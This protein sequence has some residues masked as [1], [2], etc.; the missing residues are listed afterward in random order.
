MA[1]SG[2]LHFPIFFALLLSLPLFA[3]TGQ[4]VAQPSVGNPVTLPVQASSVAS[5]SGIPTN[6]SLQINS[7]TLHWQGF[8]GNVT[9]SIALAYGNSTLRSWN[10]SSVF[11]QVYACTSQN[12]DFSALNSTAVNLSDIDSAFTFLSGADDSA[13][14]TGVADSNSQINISY[15]TLYQSTRPV[16]FSRDKAGS[17]LWQQIILS[18]GASPQKGDLVFAGIIRDDQQS[19]NGQSADFQI[20]VPTSGILNSTGESYYFYGEIQ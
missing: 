9:G 4:G 5:V 19:F 8:Y 2:R 3:Q 6:I 18:Q 7:T 13:A 1:I 11:G 14:I 10:I 20:V 16:I 15:F 17:P 12:I